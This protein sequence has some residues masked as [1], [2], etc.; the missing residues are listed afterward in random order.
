[1]KIG[2]LCESEDDE[3][4]FSEIVYKTGAERGFDVGTIEF[5]TSDGSGGIFGRMESSANLF[6]DMNCCDFAIFATDV[7]GK[8]Y[9]SK[10]VRDFARDAQMRGCKIIPACP[11]PTIEKWL[12]DENDA[13]KR[14]LGI[15]GSVPLPF[16][17]ISAPKE[18]LKNMISNR[19]REAREIT[20]TIPDYYKEMAGDINVE[21]LS[22]RNRSFKSFHNDLVSC[23][24][25]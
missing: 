21:A 3:N 10:K 23:F 17:H 24:P 11:S 12:L 25:T 14:A 13:V 8:A 18:R 15:I 4:I 1:M 5:L 22:R 2:M 16:P 9:K 7:D 20:K 6:F 19:I